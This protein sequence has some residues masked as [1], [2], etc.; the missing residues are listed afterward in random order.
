M[1]IELRGLTKRFGDLYALDN[2]SLRIE[3]GE[4]LALLGP[5]GCGKTTL[6]RVIAGLEMPATGAVSFDGQEATFVQARKRRVG[7]VFQHYALFKHMNVRDNIGFALRMKKLPRDEIARRVRELLSLFKLDLFADRYPDQLSGGQRQRV[8]LARAL[9]ARPQVL[10]LDEPFAA[11]DARI[12]QDL[13]RWLRRLHEEIKVTTVFVTHDQ[14]EAMEIAD[15]VVIMNKGRIIQTGAPEEIFHNPADEFIINFL[16]E[17]NVLRCRVRDGHA[18]IAGR[19]LGFARNLPVRDGDIR[20]YVRPHDLHIVHA[21]DRQAAFRATVKHLNPA[22]AQVKVELQSE[23]NEP[24]F[25]SLSQARYQE[26]ALKPGQEVSVSANV[27]KVFES[28]KQD[29]LHDGAPAAA[30]PT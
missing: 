16:G 7:F 15:R 13:R 21:G 20:V 6:L 10:L 18:T 23:W 12:R 25:A 11:L 17:V 22:G 26:L 24:L 5:S 2:V 4:L 30:R 28:G 9:A 14:E 29:A 3:S 27:T 19:E 1:S 8:A